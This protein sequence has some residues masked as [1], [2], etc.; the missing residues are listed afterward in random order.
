MK[1]KILIITANPKKNSLTHKNAQIIEETALKENFIISKYEAYDF[2][3][4]GK[5]PK[6]EEMLINQAQ[7]DLLEAEY[8]CIFC[9]LWNFG[10]PGALKNF[11][12][13][14][15]TS[16]VHFKFRKFKIPQGLIRAKKVYIVYTS[17]SSSLLLKLLPF[18][19]VL[20]W[21]LKLIFF[22]CGIKNFKVYQLGNADRKNTK[23]EV[24]DKWFKR[25]KNVKFA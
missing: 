11:L 16:K 21:N 6:K 7:K 22:M 24:Y 3:I 19:S 13:M 4:M 2:N 10:L 20:V 23:K 14:V 9:P 18:T 25:L 5:N 1:K 8:V 17:G 15:I 12:D